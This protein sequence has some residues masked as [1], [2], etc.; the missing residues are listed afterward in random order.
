VNVVE[1]LP[2]FAALGSG[3][4]RRIPIDQPITVSAP[5]SMSDAVDVA[6]AGWSQ[7]LSAL[8]VSVVMNQGSCTLDDPY[9]VVVVV[10]IPPDNPIACAQA[11]PMNVGPD[12]LAR[13][14][15]HIYIHPAYSGWPG[16]QAYMNYLTN[17]EFG[18]LF[19]LRNTL[20]CAPNG[21]SGMYG[22][23]TQGQVPCGVYPPNYSQTPTPS[24]ATAAVRTPYGQDG[25]KTCGLVS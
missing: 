14:A 20:N 23:E 11:I 4:I 13:D 16:G 2:V 19:G 9:C 5:E 24:D 1:C 8:G 3:P 25:R 12:G 17:H 21:R 22:E 6:I 10:D 7:Q 15:S 18:H